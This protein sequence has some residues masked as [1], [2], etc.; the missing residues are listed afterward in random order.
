MGTGV[1]PGFDWSQGFLMS[2]LL[3][4]HL[5]LQLG[6]G[7]YLGNAGPVASSFCHQSSLEVRAIL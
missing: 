5:D 3:A 4:L 7:T 1:W 2:P 6:Q